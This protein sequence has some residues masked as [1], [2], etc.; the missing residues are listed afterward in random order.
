VGCS[1][2]D[3]SDVYRVADLVHLEYV[4][5]SASIKGNPNPAHL[6]R[7]EHFLARGYARVIS[8]RV[9]ENLDPAPGSRNWESEFDADAEFNFFYP[10]TA[11][12]VRF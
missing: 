9:Q 10:P 4:S 2:E 3:S 8:D 11:R 5:S 7:Q 6:P 12:R 1:V